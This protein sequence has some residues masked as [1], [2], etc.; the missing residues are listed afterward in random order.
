MCRGA[1]LDRPRVRPRKA[2]A[3]RLS[4][5]RRPR[6]AEQIVSSLTALADFELGHA[7]HCLLYTSDAADDTL[8]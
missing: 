5:P 1:V 7:A 4:C 3:L 2:R 6:V 8:V